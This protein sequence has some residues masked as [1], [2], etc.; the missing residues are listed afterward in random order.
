MTAILEQVW[1]Q[2]IGENAVYIARLP[3]ALFTLLVFYVVLRLLQKAIRTAAQ[4]AGLDRAVK[5]MILSIVGFVGWVLALSAALSVMNLTQLSLALGGSVALVAMA[6]ATGLNNVT[7]DLM[8]GIFLLADKRFHV[9][10]RVRVNGIEG[11]VEGV[12]IRKTFIR[13]DDGWLHTVP[14]RQIDMN[15]YVIYEGRDASQR[16]AG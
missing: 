16:K 3:A 8:A 11:Y 9:G 1:A 13:T 2:M 10:A 4:L 5:T 15:T 12:T 7:Q 14:N 6:L